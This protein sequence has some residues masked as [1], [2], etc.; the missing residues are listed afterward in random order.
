MKPEDAYIY[1]NYDTSVGRLIRVYLNRCTGIENNCKNEQE[2]D[3]F[4]TYKFL[5]LLT[6]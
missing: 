3:D 4:I 2:I 5:V 1:G 6:N